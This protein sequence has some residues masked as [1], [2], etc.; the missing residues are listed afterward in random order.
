[1]RGVTPERLESEV[2]SVLSPP[3]SNRLEGRFTTTD[4]F[5]QKKRL[6]LSHLVGSY[7]RQKS[8]KLCGVKIY[9]KS[10]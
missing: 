1:M 8:S 7:F 10:V 9:E 4:S 6:R 3:D 5:P 2:C